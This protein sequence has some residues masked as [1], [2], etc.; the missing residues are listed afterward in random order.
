MKGDLEVWIQNR[1]RIGNR[2]QDR[3]SLPLPATK[4]E[5]QDAMKA[6]HI[7]EENS[8]E[9]VLTIQG[10]YMTV[11][12]KNIDIP[13]EWIQNAEPDRVNFLAARLEEMD[14]ER[15]EKLN[16][17]LAGGFQ[18]SSL[19]HLID[20]TYNE[21]CFDHIPGIYSRSE[22]GDYY[23]N[24]SGMVRMPEA[25]KSGIDKEDFGSNAAICE[26]GKFTDY[27]YIKRS[28]QEWHIQYEGKE[29][30]EQYRIMSY[31]KME[32]DALETG[33]QEE[34]GRSS[35]TSGKAER[36]KDITESV[37]VKPITLTAGNAKEKMKEITD[38]L[39]QGIQELFQSGKYRNY[40]K[41]MSKFHSYSAGNIEL[42]F[43][44][45][46][47]A[48][49]VAGYNTWK[50]QGRQV[51]AGQKG[52]KIIAPAP[53]KMKQKVVQVDEKTQQPVIGRD[54]KPV[55]RETVVT[56]PAYKVVTVF[57][58]SQTEGRELP[59]LA[60]ELNKDIEQYPDFFK[61]VE[62]TSPFPVGFERIE[63]GAH[64]YC[65]YKE[66]R[67]AIDAGMS[68]AQNI[69]TLIHEIA[70]AKLHDMNSKPANGGQMKITD[71]HTHEVQAL[72]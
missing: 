46:P 67:I 56:V 55:T 11:D 22:L 7:T 61:A 59:K 42:I 68:E 25:W 9:L 30:P 69:K 60:T 53:Y 44:Q 66:R 20:Y 6:L 54:G 72:Y 36:Q 32:R 21:G 38:R 29:V 62:R 33:R 41:V 48:S 16:A 34:H 31:P 45:M 2:E 50:Q 27:G 15:I 52:L 39:E 58:I 28:R 63:G 37:R 5:L 65:H 49:V 17:V 47:N 43:M 71:R 57:D 51:M 24:D 64:G 26:N 13:R 18:V 10:G 4:A 3:I 12:G 23:L 14:A 1:A 35:L 70:H 19:D 8:H 40:L